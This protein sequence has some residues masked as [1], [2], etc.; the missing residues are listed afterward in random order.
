MPLEARRCRASSGTERGTVREGYPGR[1]LQEY[2]S[3]RRKGMMDGKNFVNW[4]DGTLSDLDD[5]R[6]TFSPSERLKIEV[7]DPVC[8]TGLVAAGP[9][10]T[11]DGAVYYF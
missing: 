6:I 5:G 10:A 1:L 11:H 9:M 7:R 8:G 3:E 2:W 4:D